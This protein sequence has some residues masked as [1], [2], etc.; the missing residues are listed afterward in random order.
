MLYDRDIPINPLIPP[1]ERLSLVLS[2]IDRN[3][4]CTLAQ[5]D[6]R[7]IDFDTMLESSDQQQLFLPSL[8]LR[9]LSTRSLYFV[10]AYHTLI[11]DAFIQSFRRI[12]FL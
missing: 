4:P 2:K 3:L 7:A 8:F 9:S 1:E 11:F 5:R 6:R 10:Y 12:D